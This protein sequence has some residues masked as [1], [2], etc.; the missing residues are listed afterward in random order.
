MALFMRKRSVSISYE[1]LVKKILRSGEIV[2]TEMND[3]TKELRNVLI[4]ITNPS[5]KSISSKYPFGENA[6]REYVNQLLYG[7]KNKFSYDYHSRLFEWKCFDDCGVVNQIEYIIE[8]LKKEMNSRRA[9]AIT[10]NPYVD[11][12]DLSNSVSVP[13][14]QYVQFL[15]RN[16]KL[17]MS[18]VFRSNDVLLAYHSNA[19][20]LITLG[21]KVAKEIGVELSKYCHYIV[22]A[23]IYVERDKNYIRKYFYAHSL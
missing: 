9:L 5:D 19:I 10:W 8:K 17:E 7:A 14:L 16:G 1:E 4:E 18:V 11:T 21:E 22:S 6:V 12:S 3:I 20:G 15:V 13:C 2:R 23:H